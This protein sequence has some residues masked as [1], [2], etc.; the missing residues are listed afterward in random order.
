MSRSCVVRL[1]E[2]EICFNVSDDA[3]PIIWVELSQEHYFNS[4]VMEGVTE[5][6]PNIYF[7]CE[8][9]LLAKALA[10][11]KQNAKSVKFKLT[12]KQQPCF[13]VEVSLPS[14]SDDIRLCVHDIPIKMIPRKD[15]C[16]YH[17]PDIPEFDVRD[18]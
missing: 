1:T 3:I 17:A 10:Q 4:Y 12:K 14:L 15:W 8:T 13:T 2:N 7:E 16:E 5:D 18:F 9:N 11:L 6:F